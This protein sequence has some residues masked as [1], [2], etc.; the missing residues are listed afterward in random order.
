MDH[1]VGKAAPWNTVLNNATM[2]NM[3]NIQLTGNDRT[4]LAVNPSGP[5]AL[6]GFKP[7]I[8]SCMSMG[9]MGSSN[10]G[11]LTSVITSFISIGTTSAGFKRY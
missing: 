9:V 6:S 2:V 3:V 1:S 10:I 7:C 4:I 8:A 5:P 11:I